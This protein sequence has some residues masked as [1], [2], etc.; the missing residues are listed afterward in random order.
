MFINPNSK[1]VIKVAMAQIKRKEG[2]LTCESNPSEDPNIKKEKLKQ[3]KR[4]KYVFFTTSNLRFV[5][6]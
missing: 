3:S 2:K 1:H 5:A 4:I 6:I